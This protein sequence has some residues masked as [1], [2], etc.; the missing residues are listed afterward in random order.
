MTTK[1]PMYRRTL[2]K[3]VAAIA[4]LGTLPALGYEKNQPTLELV[5]TSPTHLW[6]AVTLTSSGR[7]F[8]AMPR[9]PGFTS[10]PSV[11]EIRPDGELRP[12]PGRG[13]N[14]WR[15]GKDATRAFVCVNTAHCFD[16]TYLWVVDTGSLP[17]SPTSVQ[18]GAQKLVQIDTR[19]DQVVSTIVFDDLLPA[20]ASLNDLRIGG[21]YIYLTESGLGSIV[22]V[23]LNTGQKLHRLANDPTTKADPK[24]PKIGRG[25]KWL[26]LPD[27]TPQVTNADPIELSPDNQWLYYQPASGPLYRVPTRYLI[28]SSV[29]EQTLS[30]KVEYVYDTPTLGGTAMDSSG[31]IFLAESARPRISVLAPDGSVRTLVEDDRLWGGDA[32]FIT[33][34]RYLYIP[35]SQVPDLQF[36]QGPNGRDMVQR[37]FKIFRVKLPERYGGPITG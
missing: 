6:N 30:S 24:R 26:T 7:M 25:G 27:G 3:G 36:L 17:L 15:E 8:A 20:G 33:K 2:L 19:N 10:T 11:I 32:L 13:W 21:G 1:N 9:W 37:P 23:D 22:V 34:D 14:D 16:G 35:L 29:S 31:N 28:D 12:Y 18:R 5:A 4:A